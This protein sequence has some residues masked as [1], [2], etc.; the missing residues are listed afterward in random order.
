MPAAAL[1]LARVDA[2]LG[3]TATGIGLAAAGAEEAAAIVAA[4]D[5]HGVLVFPGQHLT[6]DELVAFARRLGPLERGVNSQTDPR[7]SR[8]ANVRRSG[9]LV[10][11][12]SE[13][14]RM[15][16]GNLYWHSDSSFKRIT[17]RWSLLSCIEAPS[18]GGETQFADMRAAFEALDPARRSRVEGRSARHSY[19]WSQRLVGADGWL[20]EADWD[21][22]PSVEQPLVRVHEATGRPSLFIG[23]HAYAIVG[24]D[25]DESGRFLA[26]L[27]EWACQPPRV[28]VHRWRAGDLV[29]WDN[30][31][32]LHRGRRWPF[33]QRRIMV[34]ATVAGDAPDNEWALPD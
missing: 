3:A 9:A 33:T 24:E 26:E 27:C 29:V 14:A 19:R 28:M 2:S 12:D 34:R 23:R 32:V 22:L 17:A 15:L 6:E 31:C 8:L 20:S 7:L 4:L 11:A 13:I 1:T 21:A 16:E 5:E 10:D 18:E 25:P 30:R